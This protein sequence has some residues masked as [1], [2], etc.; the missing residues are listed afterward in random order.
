MEGMSYARVAGFTGV[1]ARQIINWSHE[2]KRREK[3]QEYRR[4]Y[5]ESKRDLV[6]FRSRLLASALETVDPRTI[7]AVAKLQ[8]PVRDRKENVEFPAGPAGAEEGKPVST[9]R[10]A[11]SARQEVLRSRMNAI[12]ARPEEL[13]PGAI[14]EIKISLDLMDLMDRLKKNCPMEREGPRGLGDETVNKIR[15]KVLGCKE[16]R[17]SGTR[18]L[19][20]RSRKRDQANAPRE[21]GT[22]SEG[23]RKRGRAKGPKEQGT[24][25][26]SGEK[27]REEKRWKEE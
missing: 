13:T 18:G 11:L 23:S 17:E 8:I 9:A 14:Q 3:R 24:L 10:E 26:E 25:S 5:G 6:L 1:T 21:Q 27:A 12:F 22:L 19:E 2:D 16:P 20:P 7:S 15:R 4:A